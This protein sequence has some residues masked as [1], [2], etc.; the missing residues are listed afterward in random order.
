[1]TSIARNLHKSVDYT[2]CEAIQQE[3][4]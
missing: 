1:V 2:V 4:Y 3:V